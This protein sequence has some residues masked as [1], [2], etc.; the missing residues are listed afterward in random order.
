VLGDVDVADLVGTVVRRVAPVAERA[1]IRVRSNVDHR[2]VRLD[3][4][5]MEQALTNLVINAVTYSPQDEVD[6]ISTSVRRRKMTLEGDGTG[7]VGVR[8]IMPDERSGVLH[9]ENPRTNGARWFEPDAAI[10]GVVDRYWHVRWRLDRG[11]SQAQRI[12]TLPAVT[13]SIEGRGCSSAARC[14]RRPPTCLDA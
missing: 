10:G 13:L 7:T 8:P 14:H 4:V 6:I 2:V 12:I 1:G 9:P 3:R 5:R 11:Q